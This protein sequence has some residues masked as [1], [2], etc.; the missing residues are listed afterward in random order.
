MQI[1]QIKKENKKEI[2]SLGGQEILICRSEKITFEESERLNAFFEKLRGN[3][4][5]YCE[6]IFKTEFLPKISFL[7]ANGARMREIKQSLSLPK[8]AELTV[9]HKVCKKKENHVRFKIEATAFSENLKVKRMKKEFCY[10]FERKIIVKS[11]K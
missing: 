6:N 5:K 1:K 9:G 7:R 4:V 3:Y 11:K 2:F 8:I 10:D